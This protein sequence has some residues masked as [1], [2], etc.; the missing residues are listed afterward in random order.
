VELLNEPWGIEYPIW[1]KCR[2]YFY[3]NGYKKIRCRIHNTSFF[4]TH[5]WA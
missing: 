4:V 5:E 1:E 3:P 2:D